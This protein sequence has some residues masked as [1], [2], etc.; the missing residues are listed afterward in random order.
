MGA[1]YVD[2]E[3]PFVC[4]R[5]ATDDKPVG[6]DGVDI[7]SNTPASVFS[8]VLRG[9]DRSALEDGAHVVN[10]KRRVDVRVGVARVE[11]DLRRLR[12]HY[13][14]VRLGTRVGRVV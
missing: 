10:D 3:R 8:R 2:S 1:L 5:P 11:N 4:K 7:K 14:E 9:H 13:A 6:P 12:G